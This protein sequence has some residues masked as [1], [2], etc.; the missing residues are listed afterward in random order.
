MR[1]MAQHNHLRA[2]PT[3]PLLFH[4]LAIDDDA[5][6]DIGEALGFLDR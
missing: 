1:K 2:C 3:T 4:G 6:V 5:D